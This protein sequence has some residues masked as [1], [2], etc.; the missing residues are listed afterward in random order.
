MRYCAGIGI[1]THAK[2]NTVCAIVKEA[3]EMLAI[4]LSADPNELISWI[5]RQE[6]PVPLRCCY[7]AWPTSFGLA[8]ALNDADIRCVVVATSKH[9]YRTDRQ[10]SDRRDAEWL[11]RMLGSGACRPVMIP[12]REEE[13]LRHLSRLRGEAAGDLRKARQRVASFLLTKKRWTKTFRRWAEGYESACATDTFVFRMKMSAVARLEE[14]LL[15]IGG[16]IM[17]VVAACPGL[18]KRMQGLTCIHGTGKAT[19]FSLVCCEVYG[20]S[21]GSGTAPPSPPASGSCPRRTRLETRCQGAGSR[22][23][24][25][26]A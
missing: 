2:S 22:N 21:V 12:A 6:L 7:E 1:D 25:T 8:R 26:S 5:E 11:A 23:R 10:K 4:K 19:T 9:P 16:E 15:E 18:Q 20:F 24:A 3:G 13:A 17:R 14:R